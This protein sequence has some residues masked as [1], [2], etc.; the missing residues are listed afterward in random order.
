MA[1]VGDDGSV[2]VEGQRFTSPSSAGS[3]VR[4]GKATNGWAFWAVERDG[5]KVPL[6]TVRARYLR[7]QD[8]TA[9]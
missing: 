1:V 6:A 5:S 4:D 2:T 9:R 8:E 3:F 7:R